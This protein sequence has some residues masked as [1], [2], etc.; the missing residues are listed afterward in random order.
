MIELPLTRYISDKIYH[1]DVSTFRRVFFTVISICVASGAVLGYLFYYFVPIDLYAKVGGVLF[2]ISVLSTWVG[3]VF[4]SAAKGYGKIIA[5]F[6]GGGILSLVFSTILGKSFGLTGFIFGYA[7]GI[8]VLA[9]SLSILVYVEF[10][11][12]EYTTHELGGYFLKGKV[13]IGIGM[14]YYMGIW[15]DKLIFWYSSIG[16]Q[17]VGP[18][19]TNPYYDTAMFLA[20]LSIIPS[21]AIFL[22]KVETSFYTYYN[23]YFKSI[24]QKKSLPFL[25]EASRTIGEKLQETFGMMLKIQT[26][27]SIMC[28]YFMPKIL[29]VFY[30]SPLIE[31]P[32]RYG[33][34]G[35]YLQV[36][37]LVMNI[38]SLYFR[39][40]HSVFW[41]YFLFFV[42]NALLTTVSLKFGYRFHGLGYVIS[43]FLTLLLSYF[44]LNR[45]LKNL[46]YYTFME[47]PISMK[48]ISGLK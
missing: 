22:V 25:E 3:M 40:E 34:I 2:L 41:S 30:L 42:S 12:K 6:V 16:V 35:A 4:L 21:L 33:I 32:L 27:V 46:N 23:F 31:S 26:F 48:W 43:C 19:Y 11:G 28:W 24:E 7:L 1:Y 17:I 20:Y 13:L 15:V 36:M 14:F 8:W 45:R 29:S 5:S 37:F 9:L 10:S 47:Q 38:L 44:N 39:D 18:F